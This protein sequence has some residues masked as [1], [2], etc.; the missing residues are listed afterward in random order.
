VSGVVVSSDS[1][2]TEAFEEVGL[3]INTETVRYLC[4]LRPFLTRTN[5]IVTPV[6]VYILDP[7]IEPDLNPDEV[8]ATR[9]TRGCIRAQPGTGGQR[10]LPSAAI[11]PLQHAPRASPP[12]PERGRPARSPSVSHVVGPA[13]AEWQTLPV[14][15]LRRQATPHRW[16]HLVR[17]SF[18]WSGDNEGEPCTA[19]SSSRPP[20]SPTGCVPKGSLPGIARSL[21]YAQKPDFERRA[22]GQLPR[23]RLL[24][25]ATADPI[26]ADPAKAAEA[27]EPPE[28]VKAK[29]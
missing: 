25:L 4:S 9:A 6:V 21:T 23:R 17:P 13:V 28:K 2:C 11:L 14:A 10:L 1:L 29:L 20:R 16:L 8:R 19:I 3:P 26:F 7:S 24:E 27:D 5:L 12:L 18:H 22:P 15:S